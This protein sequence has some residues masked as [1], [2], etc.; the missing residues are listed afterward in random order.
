MLTEV[1]RHAFQLMQ[2]NDEP[3]GLAVGDVAFK[4]LEVPCPVLPRRRGP[5]D[6]KTVVK[7]K[8]KKKGGHEFGI[9]S[10]GMASTSMR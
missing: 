3:L 7:K 10:D 4:R 2:R 1:D 9:P 5:A 8:R 6:L